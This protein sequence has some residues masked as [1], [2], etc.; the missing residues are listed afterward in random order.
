MVFGFGDVFL[1]GVQFV[2]GWLGGVVDVLQLWVF[3][4]FLLV[5]GGD[6]GEVLVVVDYVCVGQVWVVVE[7]FLDDFVVVGGVVV[8][9]QFVFVDFDGCVFGDFFFGIG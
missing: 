4:V 2:F 8:D 3:F 6:V 7:V 1:V 5:G 9:C